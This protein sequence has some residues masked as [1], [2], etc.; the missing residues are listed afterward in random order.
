M[1]LTRSGYTKSTSCETPL[2]L[3]DV[4]T[5]APSEQSGTTATST[6]WAQTTRR[7]TGQ[8]DS[9]STFDDEFEDLTE[10]IN[11]E[12]TKLDRE[13]VHFVANGPTDRT[14]T[15]GFPDP[16]IDGLVGVPSNGTIESGRPLLLNHFQ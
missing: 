9:A 15:Q 13:L 2:I 14:L 6:S 11:A 16:N 3:D 8:G 4:F 10:I 7:Y 12:L 5:T 1:A